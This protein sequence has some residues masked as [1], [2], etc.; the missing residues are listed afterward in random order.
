MKFQAKLSI[1]AICAIFVFSSCGNNTDAPAKLTGEGDA[2]QPATAPA[3]TT[4]APT[5]E[6]PQNAAGVWHYTCTKGCAGGAGAATACATCGGTLVHNQTYHGN[7]APSSSANPAGALNQTPGAPGQTLGTP[8][9]TKNEPPQNAA[10]VWHYICEAGCAGGSGA[11]GN[12]AKCQKPLL[13]NKA[14][15]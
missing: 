15:H 13:H 3:V 12:C 7:A 10:G 6:P 9:A 8:P 4:D 11:A 1:L 14:Y 2:L 5:A